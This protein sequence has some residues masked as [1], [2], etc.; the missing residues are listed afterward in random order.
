LAIIDVNKKY[1]NLNYKKT[2]SPIS[3]LFEF[4]LLGTYPQFCIGFSAKAMYNVDKG[5]NLL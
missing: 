2:K 3:G 4:V 5:Y 1:L